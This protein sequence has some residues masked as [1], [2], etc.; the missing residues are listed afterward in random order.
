MTFF[1]SHKRTLFWSR[2]S[3]IDP[4]SHTQLREKFQ[5]QWAIRRL[6]DITRLTGWKTG[7]QI[8]NGCEGAWRKAA[9]MGVAPP[10]EPES[11]SDALR[12]GYTTRRIDERIQEVDEGQNK[13]VLQRS[14]RAH[15]AFG[16][17]SID[18]DFQK[19]SV[20]D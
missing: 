3:I 15:I 7:N 10:Y 11:E 2:L 16:L 1:V 4:C 19:L 8:A 14:D 18:E 12:H 5:R 9:A 6:H 13:P 17:L 20:E